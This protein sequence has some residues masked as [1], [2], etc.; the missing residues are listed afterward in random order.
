M[1][2][3]VAAVISVSAIAPVASAETVNV[4]KI[5]PLRSDIV[6]SPGESK[7]VQVTVTNI[8][9]RATAVHPIENDFVAGDERGT[10]SLILDENKY[11][12]THSLKRFMKPL[13]DVTI[14][15]GEAVTFDVVIA[16]PKDAQAGGYFGALRFM[17]S[18]PASGG[19]VNLSP[20]AASL[21]LLRVSGDAVEQLV[22]TDF[23]IQQ[24]G[25]TGEYF[26]S[27]NDMQLAVRFANQGNLQVA[28]FGKVSVKQGDKVVYE[29]DFN[30]D[31]PKDMILP[32]SARR[33]DIL[34]KNL[35]SFGHYTVSATFTYGS[36]NETI[37]VTKSFWVVPWTII[38]ATGAGLLVLIGLVVGIWLFL[39]G[40]K[41]RILRRHSGGNGLERF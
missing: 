6:V 32:D 37:E 31:D 16:V 15:A 36:K 39:R 41:R 12:P 29:T 19:Q 24:D 25:K 26:N 9:K 13:E 10:P 8:T 5:S 2:A 20:S 17:P 11:A 1:L 27:S 34:L 7:T 23:N 33:W 3:A 38:I 22:M 18:D 14:P 40:Y 4:L 30:N 35:G 21:I 28:P